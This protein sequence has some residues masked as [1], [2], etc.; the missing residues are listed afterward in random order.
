LRFPLK[1]QEKKATLPEECRLYMYIQPQLNNTSFKG[2]G[3]MGAIIHPP[4]RPI[5][6]M[7]VAPVA[8]AE[9]GGQIG[10]DTPNSFR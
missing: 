4:T 5:Y 7:P 10:I 3:G 1:I 6:L 2:G 9:M 8:E